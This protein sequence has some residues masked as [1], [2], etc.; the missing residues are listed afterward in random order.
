MYLNMLS[1]CNALAATP[2]AKPRVLLIDDDLFYTRR[3]ALS[4]VGVA[5]L[6]V[7]GSRTA[8]LKVTCA[9]KPDIVLL[10]MFLPDGDALLLPDELRLSAEGGDIS[11]IY[12]AKG[13]GAA[14]RFQSLGGK[15][16]GV[17]HRDSGSAGL[18]RA[19]QLAWQPSMAFGMICQDA[20]P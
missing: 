13:A 9:W 14:T 4:L 17:V 18:Q 15:F 5:D 16:L 2:S 8:A 10:D 7:V 6:R 20:F 19:I 11:V 1:D 12:L 3:A